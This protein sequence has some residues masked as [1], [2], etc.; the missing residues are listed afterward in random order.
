MSQIFKA[1]RKSQN[2]RENK[3]ATSL[4]DKTSEIVYLTDSTTLGMKPVII[5][6]LGACILLAVIVSLAALAITL[7]SS[8]SK[9]IQVLVL[10][11][12]L[13]LQENRIND[14]IRA[15]NNTQEYSNKQLHDFNLSLNAKDLEIKKLI[16]DANTTEESHYLKLKDAVMNDSQEISLM[17]KND[18]VQNQRIDALSSLE[19]Q[20]K[21]L[22]NPAGG[23]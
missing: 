8:K 10:E 14:L 21:D 13:K 6:M 9:Q 7:N 17:E 12:K 4:E 5:F 22:L 19:K 23:N 1:L 15:F 20:L 3:A 11:R 18:K 16:D 2:I